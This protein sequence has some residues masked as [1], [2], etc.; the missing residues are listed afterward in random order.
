MVRKTVVGVI[1]VFLCF[2]GAMTGIASG[3]TGHYVNG[4]EGI[5]GAS[6]PPP[7]FY[8]RMYNIF[9]NA[10]TMTD[11][12]G[13]D[14]NN[15]FDLTVFANVHR[16]LWV[17][18]KKIL[19]AEFGADIF[20]PLVY[21]DFEI[22]VASLTDDDFGLGD[23][24][25]E[26]FLLSWRRARYDAAFG[27]A[28]YLPTGSYDKKEPA[29]PGKDFWTAMFTLG[30]TLY[31]DPQKTWSASLLAR[32][33]THGEKGDEDI[34]PGDDFHFEWGI[35]KTFPGNQIWE[36]GVAGYCQWQVSDDSGSDIT[37][38]KGVH[39]KVFAIGPQVNLF[40]PSAKLSLLLMSEF[41]FNAEDRPEGNVT[42]LSLIKI[43]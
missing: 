23:I 21:T 31:F 38:D 17:S 19:G 27:I 24:A 16:F 13:D 4:I 29:S 30:G 28:F 3:E 25:I 22:G 11:E 43:F 9:Y 26:P 8:Y 37:F 6:I 36:V 35:G 2:T 1:F 5:K 39:D 32:Y 41:E 20:I 34:T 33:E 10:D 14:M 15:D 12:N 42:S 7:G 18:D 40:I